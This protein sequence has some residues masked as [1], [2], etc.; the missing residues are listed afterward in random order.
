[1]VYTAMFN[2]MQEIMRKESLENLSLTCR[3][4]VNDLTNFCEKRRM[5][6]KELNVT[7]SNEEE[8]AVESHRRFISMAHKSCPSIDL[9]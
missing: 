7:Y 4:W 6:I 5:D 8:E 3:K 1:M 9:S 2:L